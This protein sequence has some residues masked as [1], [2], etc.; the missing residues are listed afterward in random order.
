MTVESLPKRFVEVFVARL[1]TP[2]VRMEQRF[3]LFRIGFG[4]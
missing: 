1:A 4:L 2:K 3:L